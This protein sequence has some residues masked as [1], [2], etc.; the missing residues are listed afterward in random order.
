MAK[1]NFLNS[2]MYKAPGYNRFDMS[3]D[4]KMPVSMGTLC[5]TM[6][7]ECV[8]GDKFNIS[9]EALIRFMP[10]VAPLFHR[11]NATMHYFFVPN[12]LLWQ[13]FEKYITNTLVG[14]SLPAFP[15]IAI[16]DVNHN[17]LADYLGMPRPVNPGTYNVN[18][19]PWAAYQM[20]FNEYYRDQNL[21]PEVNYG[22][23]DGNNIPNFTALTTLRRRAWEHDYFTAALPF[24]QKGDAVDIPL[25]DVTLKDDWSTHGTPH[26]RDSLGAFPTGDIVVDP[27]AG[28]PIA[29]GATMPTAY[30]PNGTLQTSPTTINDLRRAFRLQE[31][32][33]KAARGGSRYIESI[34]VHFGIRS[35]DKR[36]QRPEYI[37]G[38]VSPVRISEVLNTTG[39]V[40]PQGNMSGHGIA[41]VNGKEGYYRC[42]EHGY[43][44][45]IMSVMPKSGYT[46][47]IPKHFLKTTDPFD[48]Y[49]PTF[50]NLGEQ[51]ILNKEVYADPSD[52]QDNDTF[53]YIPRYAEYRFIQNRAVGEFKNSL[54]FWSLD[55]IFDPS[56]GRPNLNAEFV[57]CT[58]DEERIFA[59]HSPNQN[60]LVY[61][62]NNVQAIRPMPKYGTPTY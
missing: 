43:I 2:V 12:R 18:A 52:G 22:L 33:E 49:W 57:T 34:L 4:V 10:M 15:T 60:L 30:D 3:H 46:Q 56:L 62:H 44:I 24:A 19:L 29:T 1:N 11:I 16:S 41:T 9:A 37:T 6:A 25:G 50:A 28:T 38:N 20:I 32:L 53:G 7:L 42:E 58:P 59:A 47:G 55:R 40:L 54:D 5:P 61:L 35:S 21:I 45:G 23:S 8:P 36:L 31:W 14:G 27:G 48:F 26:M 17:L 51:E 39:D 13:N